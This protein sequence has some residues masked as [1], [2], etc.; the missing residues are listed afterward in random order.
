MDSQELF[1][2]LRKEFRTP[3][4]DRLV[5]QAICEG[6]DLELIREMLDYLE[7]TL[8]HPKSLTQRGPRNK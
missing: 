7:N 4:C 6:F 2:A 5:Q 8:A 3:E 1:E